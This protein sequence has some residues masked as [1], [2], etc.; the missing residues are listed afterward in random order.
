VIPDAYCLHREFAP[1]GPI[2]FEIDRHYLL[3]AESGTMRLEAVGRRWTLP[4]ARAALIAAGQPVSVTIL[5]HVTSASVL[6]APH[7]IPSPPA[8]AVFDVSP[9]ARALIG[10]CR[11]YGPNGGLLPPYGRALFQML[12]TVALRLA[13]VPSPLSL[14]LPTSDP[15]RQALDLTEAAAGD[16]PVFADIAYQTGQSTRALSRRF[17]EEMGMTWRQALCHIRM[18]RAVEALAG[19]DLPVTEIAFLVG[20][21]SISAFNAAFRGLLGVSPTQYRDSFHNVDR[22]TVAGSQRNNA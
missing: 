5:T 2:P 20:Y 8:V 12:A 11:E 9:L 7:V 18:M 6:F 19:T 1:E 22:S 4:P 14:P 3:Y 21:N 16:A 13:N 17:A 15:L 10:E